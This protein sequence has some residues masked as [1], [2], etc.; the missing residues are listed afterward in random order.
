[1]TTRAYGLR[2]A[3]VITLALALIA[4]EAMAQP[5]LATPVPFPSSAYACGLKRFVSVNGS[6]ANPGTH[7]LPWRTLTFAVTQV[8]GQLALGRPVTI[9]VMAGSYDTAGNEQF[10]IPMPSRGLAIEAY[11]PGAVVEGGPGQRIFEIAEPGR[12]SGPCGRVPYSLLHGL[13]I[14]GA[15][16]AIWIQPSLSGQNPLPSPEAFEVRKCDINGNTVGIRIIT[17][18]G[19]RSEHIVDDNDIHGNP[20]GGI[21]IENFGHSSTLVR[22]NRIYEQEFNLYAVSNGDARSCQPRILSNLFWRSEFQMITQDC[23]PW[24]ANNT[25]AFAFPFSGV[26]DAYG[27]QHSSGAGELITIANNIFWSPDGVGPTGVPFTARDLEVFGPAVVDTNDIEDAA[28]PFLGMNGNVRIVPGFVAPSLPYD[29]HLLPTSPLIE[30]GNR[31]FVRNPPNLIVGTRSLRVDLGV[32]VDLYPRLIDFDK[33]A[34]AFPD[35]GGDEVTLID[36]VVT[37]GAD[38]LGNVHTGGSPVT[39]GVDLVTRP[40][41]RSAVLLWHTHAQD[42]NY[43]NQ[44]RNPFGNLLIDFG[45]TGVIIV[46]GGTVPATGI[47]SVNLNLDPAVYAHERE[48]YLQGWSVTNNSVPFVGDLTNRIRLEMNR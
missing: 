4:C 34:Q 26:P 31:S 47:R 30:L 44:F 48:L 17:D 33:D 15:S 13:E 7:A 40:F 5:Q 22:S 16:T 28:S 9:N 19:W 35:I 18:F 1:M 25:I 6:N 37:S 46:G 42:P 20:F 24:V 14:R 41:D 11:E 23:S 39:V 2:G 45:G 32:D 29:V 8:Q 27:L 21:W 36:L 12:F 43:M 3:S 10:P 38:V